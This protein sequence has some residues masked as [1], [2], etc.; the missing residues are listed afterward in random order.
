MQV[1]AVDYVLRVQVLKDQQ[2]LSGIEAGS[3]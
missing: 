3:G 1:L 2:N